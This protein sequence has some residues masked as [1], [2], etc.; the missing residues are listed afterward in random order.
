MTLLGRL[1][2]SIENPAVPLT[3]TVLTDWLGAGSTTNA[4][5]SVTESSSLGM[6]AVWRAVNLIAGTCASLPLHVFRNADGGRVEQQRGWA[7]RMIES[8]HPDMTRFEV[9]ETAFA[10]IAL[11]G[12]AYFS[13][14]WRGLDGRELWPIHPSRV[15]VGRTSEDEKVI[16]VDGVPQAPDD[17]LHVPGF[18]YDGVVG[19]SPIRVARQ[20]IGL[21]LAAE[22]YGARLFGSG[23]LATGI[24]QT[25]QRLTK[26]QA[27]SLAARWKAKRSGLS[28]AHE[29]IILDSG[30]KFTQLSIPPEDAQFIESRRFQISEVARIFGIP[31]HML[32]DVEKSTS[33]GTGIE[34][35]SIAFVV[36]TLRPWLTRM[37]QRLSRL[38]RPMDAYVRFSV[39]GLLRG[40]S[41]QRARFYRQMWELGALSTN[42]IRELEERPAVDG[43]DVRYRP[44]NMGRLGDVEVSR[45]QGASE[46]AGAEDEEAASA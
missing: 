42:E 33:W 22:E 41:E 8:P 26:E 39:E 2:N 38:V 43:G 3:N 5:R 30:A 31:P 36:Y 44:L 6:P 7:A 25:E 46:T 1:F 27:D 45:S 17:V 37:E 9:F 21:A 10:H 11:W 16:T 34:Q 19:V 35:Q 12:N 28:A 40:D 18:G 24:L 15:R 23:S 32:M 29:T 13:V 4:G 14:R 20:G